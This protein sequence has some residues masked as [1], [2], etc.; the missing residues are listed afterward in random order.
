MNTPTTRCP[1][2]SGDGRHYGYGCCG[3]QGCSRC[4]RECST[5]DGE[6]SVEGYA[7]GSEVLDEEQ[8]RER[9][10]NTSAFDDCPVEDCPRCSE[11]RS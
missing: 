11:V 1:D 10:G 3:G 6:G 2:C 5:C 4:G 8:A 7:C 9:H